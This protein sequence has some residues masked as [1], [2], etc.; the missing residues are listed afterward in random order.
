VEL[1]PLEIR[2]LQKT[3]GSTFFV[4]LPKQWIQEQHLKKG[5][6][7]TLIPRRDGTLIVDARQSKPRELKSTEFSVGNN[8]F[9]D[10]INRYMTGYDLITVKA[11]KRLSAEDRRIVRD[12]IRHLIGI[13]IVD[14]DA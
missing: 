6:T 1:M 7:V 10:L 8:L 13:E 5:D 4:S 3:G 2:K 9:H 11:E 12:A 14:E